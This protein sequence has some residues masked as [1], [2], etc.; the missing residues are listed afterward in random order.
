VLWKGNKISYKG[1]LGT[2]KAKRAPS[3]HHCL[4]L[5]QF[6]I[7]SIICDIKPDMAILAIITWLS[8]RNNRK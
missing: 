5:A 4:N 2:A 6:T 8:H 7:M 3:T 1:G